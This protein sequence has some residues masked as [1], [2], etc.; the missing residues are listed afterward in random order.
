MQRYLG[1][2][3]RTVGLTSVP[4]LGQLG[5]RG[6]LHTPMV[7]DQP[8]QYFGGAVK[9]GKMLCFRGCTRR[10]AYNFRQIGL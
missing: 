4:Q 6:P 8:P 2:P 3:L 7:P 10:G 9:T 5:H 1:V